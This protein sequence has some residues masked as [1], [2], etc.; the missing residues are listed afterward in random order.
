MKFILTRTSV[1]S[2][3][4]GP[5]QEKLTDEVVQIAPEF[6]PNSDKLRY[7][8]QYIE[9]NTLEDLMEFCRKCGDDL[10]LSCNPDGTEPSVEI[11]DCYRE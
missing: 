3:D 8:R 5:N 4:T 6:Y 2:I 1:Y 10:I 11:Y 7:Y 9:F